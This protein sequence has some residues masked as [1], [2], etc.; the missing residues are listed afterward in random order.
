MQ[1]DTAAKE[2]LFSTVRLVTESD[3]GDGTSG[4]GFIIDLELKTGESTPVLITSRHVVEDAT[5]VSLHFAVGGKERDVR[6][7]GAQQVCILNGREAFFSHPDASIDIAM[8]PIGKVIL[9]APKE[10]FYRALPVSLL[11][12]EDALDALDAIEELVFVGYPDGQWDSM[13]QTPIIRR[14]ITA[15]PVWL[16]Y[17]GRPCFL[18]DGSVFEGSSGSPVLVY[19]SGGFA[20]GGEFAIGQRLILVG[21]LTESLIRNRDIAFGELDGSLDQELGLGTVLNARALSHTIDLFCANAGLTRPPA[22]RG[23]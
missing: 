17:D 7:G 14:G 1:V 13:N 11:P 23:A 20:V 22:H 16:D 6:L 4:T 5:E 10:L 3:D 2:L 15:T 8:A 9:Q 21:V 19:N 18:I 12:D